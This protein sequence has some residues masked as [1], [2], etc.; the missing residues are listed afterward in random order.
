MALIVTLILLVVATTVTLA[1]FRLGISDFKIAGNMQA[2]AQTAA[3]AQ[4]AI[5][6]AISSTRF[7]D[8]PAA[9]YPAP[10][11]GQNTFC[12]DV[13]GDNTQDVLVTL[14]PPP[15]CTSGWALSS[16]DLDLNL[17]DDQ[18]CAVGVQQNFGVAGAPTNAS[19]CAQTVWQIRAVAVDAVAEAAATITEG[20]AVRIAA[21]QLATNCP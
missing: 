7:F 3:V 8:F 20:V 15:V 10:C 19:L 21:T 6:E 1:G 5:E 18:G 2:R 17:A 12:A 11:K 13:N 14:T 16:A 4:Q 9:V